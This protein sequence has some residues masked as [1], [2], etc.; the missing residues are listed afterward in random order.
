MRITRSET[1]PTVAKIGVKINASLKLEVYL[2]VNKLVSIVNLIIF[3]RALSL[4]MPSVSFRR[5]ASCSYPDQSQLWTIRER[6]MLYVINHRRS[7]KN[8]SRGVSNQPD[9]NEG[10]V[11]RINGKLLSI[12]YILWQ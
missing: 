4:K 6:V 10:T 12:S 1:I 2:L 11:S 7:D 5:F 3:T 8:V 9:L